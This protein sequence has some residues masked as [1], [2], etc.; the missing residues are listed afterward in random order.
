LTWKTDNPVWVDQ[1][2]LTAEKV[3]AVHELVQEQLQLGHITPTNSPWNSPVFVIKK[4]SGKWRLLHDLR[5]INNAIEDMGALQPG[6]PSPTMLPR[7]WNILII[8][9]KDCFFTIPLHPEDAPRFA[10]SIPKLNRSEPM[11]RYHWTVLPQGMKNSPT[12]C[13]AF[14]A[15]ALRPVRKRFPHVYMYHYMDDILLS[16]PS[17]S[18]EQ[19]ILPVLQQELQKKGLQVAPEKIQSAA[20]WKYLGWRILQHT[21]QPQRIAIT[22]D[23]H[24]LN[25]VQKLIGN[26]NWVRTLCGIDN[27]TLA[28][29]FEL[30]KGDTDINAPRKLTNAAKRA[31]EQV[32]E[33]ISTQQCQRRAENL[34]INLYI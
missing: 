2:P 20:P 6:L 26:I 13:Q 33:K 10:F 23:I 15:E 16:S 29:L 4:K 30:L 18:L 12:I 25:D 28:P 8:D 21:I 3:A 19:E 1:W 11:D 7:D 27:Q 5:Q 22:T 24:T 14:V 31:L 34:P 17:E 9:L 32:E